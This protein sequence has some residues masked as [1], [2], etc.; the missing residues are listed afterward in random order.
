LGNDAHSGGIVSLGPV[1][2]FDRVRVDGGILSAGN[3]TIG[4]SSD[5]DGPV[6][7]FGIVNLPA[8]PVLPAFPSTTPGGS[9]T[10][11]AGTTRTLTANSYNVVIVNSGGTLSLTSGNF[12]FRTLIINASA[13]VRTANPTSPTG[14]S[15]TRVHVRDG[16]TFH[17]PFRVSAPGTATRPIFLGFGGSSAALLAAFNGK[18]VAPNAHITFGTG[19]PITYTGAFYGRVIQ[20][21]NEAD[22]VCQ[23]SR[24]P[25]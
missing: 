6:T 14:L 16:L 3:V 13:I 20:V 11:D 12:F 24:A 1:T 18:L 23:A 9:V 19:A 17:S 4:A 7:R 5:I 8:L 2:L 21:R 15:A 25:Q 22:L 10:V